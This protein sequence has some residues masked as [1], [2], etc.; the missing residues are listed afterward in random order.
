[1]LSYSIVKLKDEREREY[2]SHDSWECIILMKLTIQVIVHLQY[3]TYKN[4]KYYSD[5]HFGHTMVLGSRA[6]FLAVFC[7]RRKLRLRKF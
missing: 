3:Y 1:M 7:L 2:N 5:A 6:H 4:V